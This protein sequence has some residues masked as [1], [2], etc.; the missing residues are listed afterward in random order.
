MLEARVHKTILASAAVLLLLPPREAGAVGR[1]DSGWTCSF[2]IA[3]SRYYWFPKDKTGKP[4]NGE[5]YRETHAGQFVLT[6]RFKIGGETA[7]KLT[8]LTLQ[9]IWGDPLQGIAVRPQRRIELT[10]RASSRWDDPLEASSWFDGNPYGATAL[11]FTLRWKSLSDWSKTYPALD[12]AVLDLGNKVVDRQELPKDTLAAP[13]DEIRRA[14]IEMARVS[15]DFGNS[16]D[17][18]DGKECTYE[19]FMTIVVG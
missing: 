18:G 8:P 16:K 15:R 5:L 19:E 14:L 3:N 17:F 12:L 6:T 4:E 9:I 11:D 1:D 7:A 13:K 10:D 2:V